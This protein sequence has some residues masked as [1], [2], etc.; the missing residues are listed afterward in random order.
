MQLGVND[1]RTRYR[2]TRSV[3]PT[4]ST[5]PTGNSV[6]PP[7]SGRIDRYAHAKASS[8]RGMWSRL[9]NASSTGRGREGVAGSPNAP[10][11]VGQVDS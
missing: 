4:S 1:E 9:R 7:P 8:I 3:T 2:H 11:I 6:N 5:D 10:L